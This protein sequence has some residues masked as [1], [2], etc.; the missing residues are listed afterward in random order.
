MVSELINKIV[1]K[2]I[3]VIYNIINS[4]FISLSEWYFS[5]ILATILSLL[6]VLII[7][8][9]LFI[10]G[11][12]LIDFLIG[13]FIILVGIHVYISFKGIFHDY[14]YNRYIVIICNNL[15]ILLVIGMI[16]EILFN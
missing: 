3:R 10:G 2:N 8:G 16:G 5:Y 12:I 1:N 9:I 4:Y 7:G 13:L 15:L 11:S 6:F 14:I